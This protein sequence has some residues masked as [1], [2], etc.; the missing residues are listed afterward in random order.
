MRV[1]SSPIHRWGV[2]AGEPIPANRRV[3]EY[4]GER[5]SRRETKLRAERELNY[6]FTLNSY[7]TV[8]GS[9]GGSG[10]E[11]INHC[12]N[13]NLE[14]RIIRG[15]IYY[16][17][18]RRIRPGEELTVDYRFGHDV[19]KHTCSCGASGCRGTINL[20]KEAKPKKSKSR[21]P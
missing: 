7:W 20:Y 17:S 14:S 10:A 15:R 4:R 16:Y 21:T 19:E 12:C 1:A 5:V 8:D 6:L 11:F 18:I 13:P 3:I 9:V 2:Y